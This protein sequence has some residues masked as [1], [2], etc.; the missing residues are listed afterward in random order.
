MKTIST[1]YDY[2]SIKQ[3]KE[4]I[5][6]TQADKKSCILDMSINNKFYG[7]IAFSEIKRLIE[8]KHKAREERKAKEQ[9]EQQKR[10]FSVQTSK[11]PYTRANKLNINRATL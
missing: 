6:I 2:T 4:I 8:N 11:Y 5:T 1:T 10:A 9:V 7:C 3:G